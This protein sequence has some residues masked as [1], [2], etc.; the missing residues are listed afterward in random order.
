M[1]KTTSKLLN[2]GVYGCVYY[3]SFTC[4]GNISKS[5]STVA[6]LELKDRN[7]VNEIEISNIIKKIRH[8]DRYFAPIVRS[9]DIKLNLLT[10]KPA[11]KS[12]L[13]ECNVVK[14]SDF[15]QNDFKLIYIKHINGMDIDKYMNGIDVPTL[16]VSTLFS[17]YFYCLK[18]LDLMGD[19]GVIHFDLHAGNI[20]Y[21]L[22]NKRPMIID[23][24]LSIDISRF[25]DRD[26]RGTGNRSKSEARIDY[27]KM[28]RAFLGYKPKH[29]NYTP[30]SHFL[31]FLLEKYHGD[32]KDLDVELTKQDLMTFLND[33]II[34]NKILPSFNQ[35]T[36]QIMKS[37]Y[38]SVENIGEKYK[39]QLIKY[40]ERFVGK[41]Y[42]SIIRE[43]APAYCM[44]I[45]HYM[46]N[47]NFIKF[48]I[49]KFVMLSERKDKDKV[50]MD[51]P[52]TYEKILYSLLQI[53]VL[54]LHPVPEKRLT[55]EEISLLFK[56]IVIGDESSAILDI[57]REKARDFMDIE[58]G[59][60][61]LFLPTTKEFI[62]SIKKDV[63]YG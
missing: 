31:S 12:T 17:G 32:D 35:I 10:D 50:T 39:L 36:R 42:R 23:F 47:I 34:Y 9:C 27:Y 22:D 48:I 44:M 19:A 13:D 11:N 26:G 57:L 56:T 52:L 49:D 24:G 5:K 30:E 16:F 38:A 40:Y 18:G 14:N 21:D 29:Y 54:Q 15:L 7:S 2:Q 6:K 25:L 59:L 45:D 63:A 53:F 20:Y 3:P 8:Y 33:I 1:S 4:R 51:S 37:S 58:S 41:D 28:K 61:L 60:S 46:L 62:K 43:L 55:R